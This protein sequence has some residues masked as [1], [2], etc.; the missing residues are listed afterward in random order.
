MR[1]WKGEDN[2]VE[3]GEKRPCIIPFTSC[4]HPLC[5]VDLAIDL[6]SFLRVSILGS[7]TYPHPHLYTYLP[8]F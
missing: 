4:V 5:L 3:E 2:V 6:L 1:E 7:Y 8:S